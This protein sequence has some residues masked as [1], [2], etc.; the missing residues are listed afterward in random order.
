MFSQNVQ[1][2]LGAIPS[3]SNSQT[4]SLNAD[5]AQRQERQADLGPT[6]CSSLGRLRDPRI[7]GSTKQGERKG[8]P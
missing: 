5:G 3:P 4:L 8:D 7:L 2:C 6:K 1:A